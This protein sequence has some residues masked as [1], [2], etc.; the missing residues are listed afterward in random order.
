MHFSTLSFVSALAATASAVKT[1]PVT[2]G[3][4]GLIYNPS[5]I[6]ADVGD[7]VEFSFYP[8]NHT[9]TQSSF[10]KPCQPLAGGFFSSF[11][12]TAA[13]PSGTTFTI[14]VTDNKPIWLYCGQTT[15][16]HCQ[17]GM[18]AAI[19]APAVN[20]TLAAF[21][22][23]A[24]NTTTSTSPPSS[25]P[26]GGILKANGTSVSSSSSASGSAAAASTT[27]TVTTTITAFVTSGGSSYSTTYGTTYTTAVALTTIV[28]S[29]GSGSATGSSSSALAT[30]TKAGGVENLRVGGG[31]L[32]AAAVVA[33]AL[34]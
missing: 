34:L 27:K 28:T 10:A 25:A 8:K 31:V 6:K 3:L 33:W 17:T 26:F 19:N 11:I 24:K 32:G 23:L 7:S 20:N 4:G 2:V 12:P 29:S 22:A 5:D 14:V 30:Q 18:V 13:S 21:I 16:S 15:G 9:V 1:I